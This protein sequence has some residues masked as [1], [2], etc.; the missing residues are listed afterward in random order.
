MKAGSAPR[1]AG[2]QVASVAAAKPQRLGEIQADGSPR[3][4][5]GIPELDRVLGGGLVPGSVVL[6]A[7]EPGAGKST[8][9]LQIAAAARSDA[10]RPQFLD[11]CRNPVVSVIIEAVPRTVRQRRHTR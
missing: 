3:F 8:L 1:D 6:L 5:T 10:T 4:A 7:G 11:I 2:L 9:A